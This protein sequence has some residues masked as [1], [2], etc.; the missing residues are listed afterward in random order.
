MKPDPKYN[1]FRTNSMI[2]DVSSRLI[3]SYIVLCCRT[4]R[5]HLQSRPAM[6]IGFHPARLEIKVA[7][8]IVSNDTAAVRV[9]AKDR[10]HYFLRFRFFC[11]AILSGCWVDQNKCNGSP[12]S[13]WRRRSQRNDNRSWTHSKVSCMHANIC[14]NVWK[15][16]SG[17]ALIFSFPCVVSKNNFH[18][19][20]FTN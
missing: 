9:A 15:L 5:L 18:V 7:A 3:C 6:L 12:Q 19:L 16:R 20:Y 14:V 8:A 17:R 1:W 2:A 10:R 13:L 11:S 4:A